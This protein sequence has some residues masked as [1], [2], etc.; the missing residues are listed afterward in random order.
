MQDNKS[1]FFT[2]EEV[3]LWVKRDKELAS[4]L[5]TIKEKYPFSKQ[6]YKQ[7][8]D[9]ILPFNGTWLAG[10]THTWPCDRYA[11]DFPV[12]AESRNVAIECLDARSI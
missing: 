1:I 3:Q 2:G 12:I 9:Y 7:K 6:K 11:W 4:R 8:N 5:D 10:G